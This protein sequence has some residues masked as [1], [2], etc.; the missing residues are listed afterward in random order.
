M[1]KQLMYSIQDKKKQWFV[2][3][4]HIYIANN[5]QHKNKQWFVSFVHIYIA[6]NINNLGKHE[7]SLHW[8]T[9]NVL[10]Q[11]FFCYFGKKSVW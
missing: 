1:N 7:I 6:N 3:F 2:S 4:V 10:L 11:V 5:I 9:Y 8:G